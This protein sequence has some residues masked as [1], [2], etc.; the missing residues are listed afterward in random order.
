MTKIYDDRKV[1]KMPKLNLLNEKYGMLTVIA[2]APNI[3]GRTAW[4]CKCDCG[5]EIQVITKSLRN[6]N[7]K[8]CGC[9]H[10]KS[11][12]KDITGQRFGK[13]LAIQATNERKNGG[14]VWECQCDCGALCYVQLSLLLNGHTSSCGCLQKEIISDLRRKD[15]TN[16]QFGKLTALYPI[17]GRTTN[18]DIKWCCK[19]ECGNYIDVI[20]SSLIRGHTSSCGCLKSKG[21]AL[22]QSI[23][24]Q[25]NIQFIKEK[26]FPNCRF[27]NTGGLARFDFYLPNYNIIIEYDGEQHFH[28]TD[29]Y[30]QE[31]FENI[32][33]RDCEK[34]QYC[35]DNNIPLIRI[36]YTDYNK[37]DIKYLKKRIEECIMVS[38]L[39]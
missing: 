6:G 35:K 36:S 23:L 38:S 20:A 9:L 39:K 22:I 37:L 24:E 15:L 18:G 31:Q 14:V 7:T 17:P 1:N 26:T 19:C 29:F 21:E 30:T 33:Q 2:E 3:N 16:Q 27:K 4:L 13:L 10:K 32:Q 5:N 34:T 8:S 25:N 12:S 11:I 28:K